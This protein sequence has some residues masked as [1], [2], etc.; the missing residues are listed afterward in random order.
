MFLVRS[1]PLGTV[2]GVLWVGLA[3]SC[4]VDEM[5]VAGL[6][7]SN[8][9]SACDDFLLTEGVACHQDGGQVFYSMPKPQVRGSQG[10]RCTFR[11]RR[12]RRNEDGCYRSR[13]IRGASRCARISALSC[14]T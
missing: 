14:G 12:G 13:V 10:A 3:F 1:T 6:T 5:T 8:H 11:G 9:F 2:Y 4:L 7:A